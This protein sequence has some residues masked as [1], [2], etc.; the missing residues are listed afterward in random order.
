[1]VD[2]GEKSPTR[3]TAVATGRIS[4]SREAF[5]A[6][7]CGNIE[8]GN[9]LATAKIAGIMAAK[10]TALVIP[11][12]HPLSIEKVS[13]DFTNDSDTCSI[14]A[15]STVTV[16]GKT[17]VE[18]EAVHAVS[19]AL[20]TIYDMAKAMDKSMVITDICLMEKS[21]GKSGYFKRN[22]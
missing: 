22:K 15:R 5:N 3:R 21:G 10:N 9:V 17:G 8:K 18:M 20:I 16:S 11:L 19:I 1:M 7:T 4:M 13:I 12:C 14:E 6:I 2:V